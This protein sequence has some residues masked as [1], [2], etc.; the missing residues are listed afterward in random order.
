M[1]T[2]CTLGPIELIVRDVDDNGKITGL[3][4]SFEPVATVAAH[5]GLPQRRRDRRPARRAV[6]QAAASAPAEPCRRSDAEPSG[7]AAAERDG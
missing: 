7:E 6:A 1:P 3:G 4:L 2:G 5:S